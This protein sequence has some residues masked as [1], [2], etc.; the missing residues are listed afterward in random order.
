MGP[1]P[2]PRFVMQAIV[3]EIAVS[4]GI[5]A[6]SCAIVSAKVLKTQTTRK[7]I[8]EKAILSSMVVFPIVSGST[9]FG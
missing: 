1:S 4:T 9:A 6:M 2:G 7:T 8:T 3:A 5:P